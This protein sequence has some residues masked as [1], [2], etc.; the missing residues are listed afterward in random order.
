MHSAMGLDEQVRRRA[1]DLAALGYVAL[2]TDMYAA[3]PD[4]PSMDEYTDLFVE[5]QNDPAKRA[6]RNEAIGRGASG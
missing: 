4:G 5:L 3:G 6:T 2:A 1:R